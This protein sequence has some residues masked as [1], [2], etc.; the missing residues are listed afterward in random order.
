MVV[1]G[2]LGTAAGET[3]V[4]QIV[5]P[6]DGPWKIFGLWCQAV[7]ATATAGESLSGYVR[8]ESVAGDLEPNPAPAR[9]PLQSHGSALGATIDQMMC[10]LEVWPVDY[11]APG[12]SIMNL[13][14]RQDFAN[15]VAPQCVAG[16][17]FGRDVPEVRRMKFCDSVTVNQTAAADT[18]IG[19]IT[20]SEGASRIVGVGG[21]LIQGNVLTTAEELIGFWRMSSD[22]V[23]VVPM[24]L[25]FNCAW[26]AGLGALINQSGTPHYPMI[27]VDVPVVAGARLDC[28]VD[29]NTAVTNAAQVRVFVAY[30]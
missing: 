14:V 28:Y 4:G 20:M 30:E 12:K 9:F 22:D 19:T 10:P 27:P 29:L 15:T 18:A 24:Q 6:A 17:L 23:N 11:S 5:L 21:T 25:P 16:I 26:G 7:D 1:T 2:A 13:I 3:V 8:L